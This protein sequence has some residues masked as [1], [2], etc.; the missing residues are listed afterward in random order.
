MMLR[1]KDVLAAVR[2]KP[3][4]TVALLTRWLNRSGAM[5]DYTH[6]SAIV[7][8]LVRQGKL[9]RRFYA[10]M[11]QEGFALTRKAFPKG[12]PLLTDLELR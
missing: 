5:H 11:K 10:H 3:G 9:Q 6:V 7:Y 1:T 12:E 2:E 4:F 8:A